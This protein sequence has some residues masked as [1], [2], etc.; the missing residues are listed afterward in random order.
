MLYFIILYKCLPTRF[1]CTEITAFQ[2]KI[3]AVRIY[4]SSFE[5]RFDLIK[6]YRIFR[7][8][9]V[10]WYRKRFNYIIVKVLSTNLT[11]VLSVCGKWWCEVRRAVYRGRAVRG[12]PSVD[13]VRKR[14]KLYSRSFLSRGLWGGGTEGSGRGKNCGRVR[15]TNC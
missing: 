11:I 4:T 10:V 1:I 12:A 5:I 6:F 3:K 13:R 2:N 9:D 15:C 14:T 8:N 7:Y